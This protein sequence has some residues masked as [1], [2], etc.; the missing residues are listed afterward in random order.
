[1]KILILGDTHAQDDIFLRILSA[2][3]DMDVML[4]TGDFEGSEFVYRELTD[5]PFYYVAGNND[6]F[7]DA[8][9]ERIVELCGC[10][11]FMTHGHRYNLHAGYSD[12]QRE[13]ARRG[14]SI[15]VYGHSHEPV[16]EYC[17]G[18]LMLNPGSTSW[19]RQENRRPSYIVLT[20]EDGKVISYE[21]R[22]M[23]PLEQ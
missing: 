14:A 2:E 21:I 4:H 10:R 1:M 20:L 6:F 17:K 11:I 16:A 22:Y 18:I 19:P 13:A 12:L 23:E 7:T 3:E 15:A 5:C 8:P 9:Y